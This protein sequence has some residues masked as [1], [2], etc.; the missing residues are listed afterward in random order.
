MK[1][2][3]IKLCLAVLAFALLARL[4]VT[5]QPAAEPAP[6]PGAP[7]ARSAAE[8][9]KLV[10][11]IALH[12]DP[13]IAVILPASVYPLEIVQAARFV[14]DTNNIPKVDQ[15]D[16]DENIKAVAKFPSLIA[17]MDA[18]LEWTTQLGQ[19]FLDQPQ[20]LMDA[21]QRMRLK[22]QQA[23]TLRNSD[24]Q[25]IVVTN[26]IVERTVDQ[27][28]VV[29]TNTIVE[30][31]PSNP[32]VVYVPSYPPTVYYPPPAYVYNPYAPLITFGAGMAVGAIIANN[33]DWG[34]GDVY[35]GGDINI[36]NDF[37]RN[38]NRNVDRDRNTTR[39]GNAGQ[40]WQPDQ[41]R[42]RNS[43]SSATREARGWTSGQQG[44]GA[45][46]ARASA[47]PAG[48]RAGGPSTAQTRP[49]T[50]GGNRLT[51]SGADT[52]RGSPGNAATRPSPA[53]TGSRSSAGT[54][55]SRPSSSSS[56]RGS[57]FGGVNSGGN[58]Q[59]YSNRGSSSRSGSAS[60]SSGASRS[61]GG[62]SRGGGGR[63][64]GRR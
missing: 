56:S 8:L 37:N 55:S 46:G 24:Q 39:T 23:G 49:S 30:I 64:G 1:T 16:W 21:I 33:C 4:T 12:P 62:G 57:A 17:K 22:A 34:H 31:Q 60:R 54:A 6:P 28:V 44:A 48:G 61:G 43:G 5:A 42:M 36:N 40:K 27:Q 47:Q 35:H 18:D 45:G 2:H 7:A 14:K 29:V 13:L 50:S 11:P 38:V 20:E 53:N 15:Q 52:G 59:N 51:P 41:N 3:Q 26:S 9:E 19:A 63:G 25:V 10:E 32:E 58:A